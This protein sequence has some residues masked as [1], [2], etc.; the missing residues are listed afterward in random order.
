MG[1]NH[2]VCPPAYYT[3]GS[4]VFEKVTIPLQNGKVFTV[5]AP[6]ASK[7]NK[8]IDRAFLNDKELDGPFFTHE[9]LMKGA[10]LRLVMTNRPNK[11]W[12]GE[13]KPP[14]P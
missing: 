7:E 9:D 14:M 4:P 1:S 11:T 5:L 3:I 10:T 6:G 13:A 8:Y 2:V 12:G